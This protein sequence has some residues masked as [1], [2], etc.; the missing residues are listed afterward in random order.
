MSMPSSKYFHKI[1]LIFISLSLTGILTNHVSE[2][3]ELSHGK[4]FIEYARKSELENDITGTGN[5]LRD[6]AYTASCISLN[7]EFHCCQGSLSNM[8]CGAE[9]LCQSL[10]EL[11]VLKHLKIIVGITL[12]YLLIPI[13]WVIVKILEKNNNQ[14]AFKFFSK[15][16]VV[17][18]GVLLPPYGIVIFIEN[19]Y[20]PGKIENNLENFE[21]KNLNIPGGAELFH[22]KFFQVEHFQM[23]VAK[24]QE[25]YEKTVS[26]DN[27]EV[28]INDVFLN[29]GVQ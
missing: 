5:K 27:C 19:I 10:R 15:I 21:N 4:N 14:S 13:L 17:Y 26:K 6:I 9:D 29:Y 23:G 3:M 20:C 1:F 11:N 18:T 24:Y 28:I 8:T 25:N 7:C 12:A 16:L 2:S 22:C